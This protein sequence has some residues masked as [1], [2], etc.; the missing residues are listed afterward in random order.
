[1]RCIDCGNTLEAPDGGVGDA[2]RGAGWTMSGGATLCPGCGAGHETGNPA[3]PAERSAYAARVVGDRSDS[4]ISP[5]SA[6]PSRHAR[7]R[8]RGFVVLAAL[9]A[10]IV[11]LAVALTAGNGPAN[12]DPVAQAAD[13]TLRTG[14][15]DFTMSISM[16]LPGSQTP[17]AMNGSGYFDAAKLRGE[18]SMHLTSA[19]SNLGSGTS[20]NGLSI[21]AVIDNTTYYMHIPSLASQ[22]PGGKTWMRLDMGSLLK[23]RYGFSPSAFQSGTTDPSQFLKMLK[24]S[25]AT[26]VGHSAVRGVATTQYQ[27]TI[28]LHSVADQ[29]P[30]DERS[31]AQAAIDK[32]IAQLGGN[33]TIPLQAWIDSSRHLRRMKMRIPF[34]LLG[35]NGGID[36]TMDMFDFGV[37]R[38]VI[39]PP[40]SQVFDATTLVA[41]ALPT[42]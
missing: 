10:V 20:V 6:R 34:Q 37:S 29:L 28:D 36:V 33:S 3:G 7:I 25:H 35:S 5:G 32:L 13:S 30:A 22:L 41:G 27:G 21:D 8:P 42:G 15:A 4:E 11:A 40:D 24:A 14:G 18:M 39:V 38:P 19:P 23:Q 26:V 16:A 9:V 2:M 17:F 1:M 12:L 31:A